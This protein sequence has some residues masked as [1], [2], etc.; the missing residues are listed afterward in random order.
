LPRNVIDASKLFTPDGLPEEPH[1]QTFEMEGRIHL[2]RVSRIDIPGGEG[3]HVLAPFFL[4]L[5]GATLFDLGLKT[6]FG[7]G[8]VVRFRFGEP[9][10]IIGPAEMEMGASSSIR[11]GDIAILSNLGTP[12]NAPTFTPEAAAWLVE[13]GAK[14]VGFDEHFRIDADGYFGTHATFLSA[15]VPVIRNL[16]N[17]GQASGGRVAV[18]AFPLAMKGLASSPVRVVILD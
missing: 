10:S 15:G 18:M 9:G 6:F 12:E 3:T 5:N 1:A 11:R 7:E 13:R 16:V 14:M 2:T 4:D 17:L 8:I